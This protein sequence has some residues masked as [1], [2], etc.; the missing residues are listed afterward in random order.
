MLYVRQI[1]GCQKIIDTCAKHG[2][3]ED[4]VKLNAVAKA[5]EA[6]SMKA[7]RDFQRRQFGTPRLRKN[8]STITQLTQVEQEHVPIE[9]REDDFAECDVEISK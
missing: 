6:S 4:I 9:V 3:K 2:S 5:L 7:L 1:N 8:N